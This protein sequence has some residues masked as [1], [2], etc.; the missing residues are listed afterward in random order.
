MMDGNSA[1]KE[2]KACQGSERVLCN[3]KE[4]HQGEPYGEGG[5]QPKVW[6]NGRTKPRGR[7]GEEC[8]VQRP[9]PK[10]SEVGGIGDEKEENP[11]R[12]SQARVRSQLV[13]CV[14]WKAIVKMASRDE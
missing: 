13:L 11:G 10:S 12:G 9:Q 2:N 1:M 6:R 8:Q 4:E 7:P 14:K 3:F 5:I